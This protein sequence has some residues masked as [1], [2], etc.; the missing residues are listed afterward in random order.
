[1]DNDPPFVKEIDAKAAKGDEAC[2]AAA[3]CL[4]VLRSVICSNLAKPSATAYF[5]GAVAALQKPG[6]PVATVSALLLVLRKA[7]PAA[8]PAAVSARL[9]D[10][11]L[12]ITGV[13]RNP[14]DEGLIKQS[15]S[16]L[17]AA[18][19]AVYG[20]GGRP[21][22]KVLKPVFAFLGDQRSGIRHQ[23]E[24][25]AMMIIKKAAAGGDQ[26][27]L[28]FAT[29]H[30]VQM[31]ACGRTNKKDV[32][33]V[34]AKH[35]L[36]LVRACGPVLPV[37]NLVALIEELL[38]LPGLIG[39]HP[40]CIE[41]FDFLEE[42]F[43]AEL[44]P[45]DAAYT[46][47]AEL[48]AKILPAL[49]TAPVTMLNVNFVAAFAKA[50]AKCAAVL[51]AERLL[52]SLP[53][54][55]AVLKLS[56]AKKLLGLFA[57]HDPTVLKGAR[58]AC[59]DYFTAAGAGGD[60]AMLDELPELCKPLL[61]HQ[62]KGAWRHVL[63]VVTSVFVS[64]SEIRAARVGLSEI[65]A[66]TE[67]RFSRS[68][69]LVEMLVSARE[70]AR[71]GELASVFG[72]Q[73]VECLGGAVTAFG[74]ERVLQVAD[75]HILDKPLTSLT[76]EHDSRSWLLL[77][78]QTSCR[79]T[80]LSYFAAK[81]LPMATAL[82]ARVAEAEKAGQGIVGKKYLTLLEQVWSLLPGFFDEALDLSTALMAEGG[83]MAKQL[84]SVLNNEPEL[85]D[86]VWAAFSKAC[87]G[88]RE[89]PSELAKA[90]QESNRSCLQTLSG[91]ILPEMF[92]AYC[93]GHAEGQEQDASRV[94][95]KKSLA[96]GAVQSYVRIS[97]GQLVGGLFKKLVAR[98]LKAVSDQSEGDEKSLA[99]PLAELSSALVPH[100]LPEF[101]ELAL[102]V[103]SPML[104]GAAAASEEDNAVANSLQKAA[105]RAVLGML[106]HPTVQE[107]GAG[108][109][110]SRILGLWTT[111]QE[112]RQTCC[113]AAL[114]ARLAC[115]DT[116]LKLTEKQM[117]PRAS[118][119]GVKQEYLK[120]LQAI[121]PEIMFHIRD[122]STAVREAARECLQVAATTALN[123][124][125]QTEIVTL[126][127]AGL[128]GLTRHSKASAVDALSRVLY[129]H[130]S[131]L[132]D[133]LQDRLI[134]VVLMLLQ[135]TDAQV[136][137]SVLKFSKVVVYV[138]PKL[139]L[140][141]LLPHLLKMFDSRHV[142]T[143]KMLMR[144]IVERLVKVLPTDV[145]AEAFPDKHSPLLHYVQKLMVK[146]ARPQSTRAVKK[147]EEKGDGKEGKDVEMEDDDARP[148]ES[149]EKFQN[150]DDDDDDDRPAAKPV[151]K[152]AQEAGR[153]RGRA[154]E[155]ATC[156]VMAHDAVQSLLDAWEA[157][158]DLSDGEGGGGG[159]GSRKRALKAGK[160]KR[161][162]NE[163]TSTWI[164]EDQDVP[165]DFMSADAAHSVL[166]VRPNAAKRRRG[167]QVGTAGATSR[168]E[169]LRRS[170]LRFSEDGRLVVD[171]E[172]EENE[173]RKEDKKAGFNLGSGG[174]AGADANK[175]KALSRLADIRKKRLQ[176]KAKARSEKRGT[177]IIKG[178]DNY[179]PGKKADGDASRSQTLEPF[180][181]VRLN[182]KVAK[183]KF[184]DKAT[185]SF[186]K[187]IK[188]AKK[189]VVKGM[190]AK[191]RDTKLRK[192][193]EVRDRRR[194]GASKQKKSNA[195]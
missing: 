1:M 118:E 140:T 76:Y 44:A 75:L 129:E 90:V 174:K 60:L 27:S 177:H 143:A 6:T 169:A 52:P 147:E 22:R 21:N 26:Q 167:V 137:R 142:A 56:A 50:L 149:F 89:P 66:W 123:Q 18:A 155:P 104:S 158:S 78:L 125:L 130:S 134:T 47:R 127:S 77:V 168:A 152:E 53:S 170:G 132:S 59:L 28:D 126:I 36:T 9:N 195:R 138:V 81:F 183:E 97:D 99:L 110:T 83:K 48:A 19:D 115:T 95:Y 191:T 116:M 185:A 45:E 121:L 144:S 20:G 98:L 29:Q 43:G 34:P 190:K 184:K 23:A 61:G 65:Q 85:R 33:E 101:L 68:R 58:N 179:K 119:P 3:I 91:R 82:K 181:Y 41:A 15:L 178:L 145:L 94:G 111:L 112:S 102:K 171:E 63:P 161:D 39:Q 57:E 124:E 160:R 166:T 107:P 93:K 192:A 114:K 80:F 96:L 16:S 151:A 159:G 189:G 13:L 105:Y 64:L 37:A 187:V 12:A 120:I 67:S 172:A 117:I 72:D 55:V 109:D 5:A 7:I 84:V 11:A 71:G 154:A 46:A 87:D 54:E 162:G 10:L 2:K 146:N 51:C 108:A 103:F 38:K 42:H 30:L 70:K 74:P 153:K 31:I 148:K 175:P 86:Y 163:G 194:K 113:P 62:S 186:A 128:A 156:G 136:W 92:N 157:E 182:P 24:L 133:D 141:K 139:R 122:Q 106:K 100:L 173:A 193:K 180:A 8:S 25:T 17:M 88:I 49:V 69:I 188:G 165:L 164:H 73:L 40:V 35:A 131:K 32:D 4:Q 150:N 79:Y 14:D 135:D 176:A